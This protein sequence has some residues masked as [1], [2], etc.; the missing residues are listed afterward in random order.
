MFC[1]V[2]YAAY[3]RPMLPAEKRVEETRK[4]TDKEVSGD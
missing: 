3:D 2:H 1:K 4:G